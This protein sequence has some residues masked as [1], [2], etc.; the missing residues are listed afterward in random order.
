VYNIFILLMNPTNKKW[1]IIAGAV[2]LLILVGSGAFF[3]G[4]TTVEEPEIT[5][6]SPRATLSPEEMITPTEI[7]TPTPSPT[8]K[9]SPSVTP[10]PKPTTT[11]TPTPTPAV[12]NIETSVSPSGTTHSCSEQTFTFTAKIYVNA[13]TNVAYT[14]LRSDNATSPTVFLNFTGAGMQT[15]TTTWKMTEE[16]GEHYSGWQRVKVTSPNDAL[17]NQAEF[18]LACP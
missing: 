13:A 9:P 7:E 11:P 1:M 10:T 6:V 2:L 17:G 3:L 12:V 4:R 14:W 16:N 18:T 5:R 15:V 8:L